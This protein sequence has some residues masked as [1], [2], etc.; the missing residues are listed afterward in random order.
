MDV[1]ERLQDIISSMPESK[2]RKLLKALQDDT[3]KERRK[4]PRKSV[5][6][7]ADYSKSR[8]MFNDFIKNI[9]GNGIFIE[10]KRS[11]EVGE[12]MTISFKLPDVKLPIKVRG[13]V[14]RLTP[15][16]IGVTFYWQPPL[17]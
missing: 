1:F 13:K 12:E 14:A 7:S 17:K 10:T 11:F 8:Q 4:F 5:L 16:G 2:Q 3:P 15:E 9:S 6:I